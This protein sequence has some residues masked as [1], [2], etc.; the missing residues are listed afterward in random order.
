M[1]F[2]VR[3]TKKKITNDFKKY[4]SVR[5][6][7]NILLF[8]NLYCIKCKVLFLRVVGTTATTKYT[9]LYFCYRSKF[10]Y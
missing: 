8:Y 5:D 10:D 3:Q 9:K 7:Y 2:F 4:M 6:V 1:F